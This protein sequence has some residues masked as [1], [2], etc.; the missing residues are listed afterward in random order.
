MS[1]TVTS[2]S[3]EPSRRRLLI[4]DDHSILRDGLRAL[5][6]GADRLEVVGAADNSGEILRL[7]DS[8]RPQLVLIDSLM[9]NMDGLGAIREIKRRCPEAKVLVLTASSS[10]QHIRAALLAG[11][12]GYLLKD[13]SRAELLM[14]IEC[15]LEGKRF[16][17]PSVSAHIVSMYLDNAHAP[18]RTDSLF[19]R[20]TAREKQVL[21][22]IAEGRRNREI[23]KYLFISVKTVEKHR[24]NL[25]HKM[26]LHNTAA[27][28]G[29]AMEQGLVGSG[30]AE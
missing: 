26:D 22:L 13:A 12:D 21:K 10:E 25:M 15:V 23:A 30:R 29:L 6:K 8:A 17:S 16:I 3:D 11:A 7:L 27:L 1:D 18:T 9:R 24:S 2:P 5:L 20:L 19:D 4:A 28:T 14:A